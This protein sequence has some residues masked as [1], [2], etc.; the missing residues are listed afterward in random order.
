MGALQYSA[1]LEALGRSGTGSQVNL[2]SLAAHTCAL[3]LAACERLEAWI[4]A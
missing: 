1:V 2:Y 3:D 4:A